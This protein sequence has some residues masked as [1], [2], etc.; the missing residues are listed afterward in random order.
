[1]QAAVRPAILAGNSVHADR[2]FINKDLPQLASLLHYR[3]IDVSSIK[4]LAIRWYTGISTPRKESS[5][6]RAMSDIHD[7]IA[8]LKAYRE[9]VFVNR[10]PE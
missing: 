2:A 6:H 4:E 1:M 10:K 9:Q 8:E 7:S 5:R 3:I